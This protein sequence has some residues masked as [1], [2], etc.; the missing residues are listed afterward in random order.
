M[1]LRLRQTNLD[2]KGELTETKDRTGMAGKALNKANLMA[3]GTETLAE[4]LLETVKGDAARQ[5]RVR[6]VLAAGQGA[7][8]VAV[9]VRKRFA[10]IR[11]ARSYISRKKQRTLAKELSE[12]TELIETR[13]AESA[14]D[15]AF[16][17][18]WEQLHLARGILERTDDAWSAIGDVMHQA[19]EAV[20][21]LS[22]KL[23][24]PPEDLA[25]DVFDAVVGD[26]FGT[27]EHAVRATSDALGASGMARLKTLAREAAEAPAPEA[28]I[29]LYAV[30]TGASRSE[31]R[32][33]AA[34]QRRIHLLLQDLADLEGDV[35]AW[36]AQYT[37][38]QLTA[39]TVAPAAADRLLQAGRAEEALALVEAALERREGSTRDRPDL[40][41]A[42]FACLEALGRKDDLIAA[43]WERF[44]TRLCPAAL[45]WHLKLLPDFEDIEAE[46]RARAHILGY[47][48]I[49][50]AL[51]YC[52]RAPDLSLA[53]QLVLARYD[54]IDG[55]AYELLSPLADE[56]SAH[57][58]LAAVLL[59]RA[60]IDFALRRGRTGRYGH[61]ARHL[62]ACTTADMSIED[63]AGHP[64]H[65]AYVEG[66]RRN[67]GRKA[68]FW[69]RLDTE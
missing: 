42:H 5:R 30:L 43:L 54:E 32:A 56:L 26:V 62:M 68:A 34:R 25:E 4:L 8:A 18:L 67:Y 52:Q 7:E 41:E 69:E 48:P 28:E 19:M 13:I 38:Q 57:H 63:Y 27:F 21:R 47:H 60:M 61:A 36:L 29:A 14:P 6:L 31:A 64:S 44:E 49:Q 23:T 2:V 15:L 65:Y 45:Q 1:A 58:P 37:P 40:D 24:K 59:W 3:L 12:L 16:D 20:A 39:E 55:E 22:A 66:L 10:T 9:D 33:K 46:D 53:A 50:S 51:L 11:K 17:L 35:D